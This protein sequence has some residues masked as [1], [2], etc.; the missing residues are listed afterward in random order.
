MRIL[1]AAVALFAIYALAQQQKEPLQRV[2]PQYSEEARV[3]GLEGAVLVVGSLAPD[4]SLHDLRVSRPLGLGLDERALA[5]GAQW[6]FESG[7]SSPNDDARKPITLTLDFALPTK[8]SHWHLVQVEFRA[9]TGAS[10]PTFAKADYPADSGTSAAAFDEA[11][12]L[13]AIGRAAN[14]TVSFD[15]NESGL[16]ENFQVLGASHEVWGSEAV[17]LLQSWRFHPGMKTGAPVSVPCKLSLV[18]GPQDFNSRAIASQIDQFF[19]VQP[20][21]VPFLEAAIVSKTEPE[22]TDRA[23]QAGIEGSL[24]MTLIVDREGTPASVTVGDPP[25]ASLGGGAGAGLVQNA[26]AAV[27]EWRFE[28]PK[29]L[30]GETGVRLMVQVNFKLS[31]VESFTFSPRIPERA[32]ARK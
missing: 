17:A 16:P 32:S 23:R 22:Y 21:G 30:N 2:E 24:I 6:R 4:G 1:L 7:G 11:R 19:P 14:A 12:L 25:L 9:P 29:I 28:P 27:R 8:Q 3:A 5:A 13:T 31:G 18:W 15:I 20:Q 26:L 10:R